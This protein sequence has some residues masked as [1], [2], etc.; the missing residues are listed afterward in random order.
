VQ[1][2]NAMITRRGVLTTQAASAAAPSAAACVVSTP[3]R[4]IM[5]FTPCT[6][7]E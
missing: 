1:G 5:A 3:L 7:L 6:E 2:V 4:V